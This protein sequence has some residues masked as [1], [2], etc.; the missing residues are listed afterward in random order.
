MGEMFQKTDAMI[1][2]NYSERKIHMAQRFK[3]LVAILGIFILLV[4]GVQH[5]ALASASDGGQSFKEKQEAR[6]YTEAEKFNQFY[7]M[8]FNSQKGKKHPSY[9]NKHYKYN[10]KAKESK[11]HE[12]NYESK[13]ET[14]IRPELNQPKEEPE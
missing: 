10:H 8:L 9:L 11:K 1:R 2:V 5:K 4:G 7:H 6:H 14:P 3:V 13:N 12:V